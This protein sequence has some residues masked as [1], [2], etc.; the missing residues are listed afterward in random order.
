VYLLCFKAKDASGIDDFKTD[1]FVTRDPFANQ[2]TQADDPF[3][4]HDPFTASS[5]SVSFYFINNMPA[6]Y[7]ASSLLQL[8][9]AACCGYV[10]HC[11]FSPC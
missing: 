10:V 3:H 7:A 5:N 2:T 9:V 6:A 11:M 1:P 4:S 8:I